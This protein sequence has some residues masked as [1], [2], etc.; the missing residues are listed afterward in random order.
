MDHLDKLYEEATLPLTPFLVEGFEIRGIT[1]AM[2]KALI[3]VER[4]AAALEAVRA[5][6]DRS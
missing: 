4:A 2:F 3:E 6:Q 1:R 5:I